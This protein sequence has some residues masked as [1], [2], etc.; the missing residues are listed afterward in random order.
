MKKFVSAII[1]LTFPVAVSLAQNIEKKAELNNNH[2]EQSIKMK[3]Q[4][5]ISKT[6][7]FVEGDYDSEIK[8]NLAVKKDIPMKIH[9]YD[10]QNELKLSKTLYKKGNHKIGFESNDDEVYKVVIESDGRA[11]FLIEKINF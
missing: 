11:N 9:V 4:K 2:L 3:N 8:I 7:F 10:S 1:L 5:A 6:E